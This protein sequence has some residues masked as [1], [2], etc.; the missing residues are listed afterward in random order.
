MSAA[1]AVSRASLAGCPPAAAGR[2]GR[3]GALWRPR[4]RLRG[5]GP[6]AGLPR[7]LGRGGRWRRQWAP[8]RGAACGL[9]GCLVSYWGEQTVAGPESPEPRTFGAA[10]SQR[11]GSVQGWTPK[12]QPHPHSPGGG[13]TVGTS[14]SDCSRLGARGF[15]IPFSTAP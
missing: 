12:S 2:G 5:G 3:G 15:G 8:F 14:W 10:A 13:V 1:R 4:S 6:P 7:Q 9:E 11:S